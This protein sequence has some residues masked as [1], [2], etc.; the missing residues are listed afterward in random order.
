M[1]QKLLSPSQ[2]TTPFESIEGEI[3]NL[4]FKLIKECQETIEPVYEM[5]YKITLA[6]VLRGMLQNTNALLTLSFAVRK[7]SYM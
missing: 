4:N 1:N 3:V 5:E 2:G 6:A 7:H